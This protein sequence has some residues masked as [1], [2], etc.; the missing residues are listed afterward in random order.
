MTR[1]CDLLRQIGWSEQSTGK[2]RASILDDGPRS[3][4]RGLSHDVID[5]PGRESERSRP[6]VITCETPRAMQSAPPPTP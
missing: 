3:A 6:I 1:E 2:Q 5:V 4:E